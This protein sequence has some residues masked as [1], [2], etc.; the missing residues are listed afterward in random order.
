MSDDTVM[1]ATASDLMLI[2]RFADEHTR[3]AT[4]R[5]MESFDDL[6]AVGIREQL[7]GATAVHLGLSSLIRVF[8]REQ[9]VDMLGR[10]APLVA[11]GTVGAE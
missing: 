8:G 6:K 9:V 10:L 11:D 3:F 2:Q 1:K 5:L 4:E 7:V